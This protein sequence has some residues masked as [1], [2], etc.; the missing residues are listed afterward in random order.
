MMMFR[1]LATCRNRRSM[2]SVSIVRGFAVGWVNVA[3]LVAGVLVIV[4]S[5]FVSGMAWQARRARAY[6]KAQSAF[7]RGGWA[8]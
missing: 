3:G 2:G 1:L 5:G 6:A 8:S 7:L 4:L